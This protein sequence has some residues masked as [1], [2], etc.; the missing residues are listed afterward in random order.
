MKPEILEQYALKIRNLKKA[1]EALSVINNSYPNTSFEI[2]RGKPKIKFIDI[3]RYSS[4]EDGSMPEIMLSEEKL[5]TIR[6]TIISSYREQIET[7]LKEA[8][9]N[10]QQMLIEKL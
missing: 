2:D 6:E 1:E 4:F 3:G 5:T 8:K 9:K 7:N 10:F